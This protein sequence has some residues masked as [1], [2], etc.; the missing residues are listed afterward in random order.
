M[1]RASSSPLVS[2]FGPGADG[3]VR[4]SLATEPPVLDGAIERIPAAVPALAPG[5]GEMHPHSRL[6]GNGV[7][8]VSSKTAFSAGS[9]LP[10]EV[11]TDH[12]HVIERRPAES[13]T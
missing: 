3:H 7:L 13:W 4:L 1:A 6:S 11:D 8:N 9:P 5:A 12:V 2:E 10:W